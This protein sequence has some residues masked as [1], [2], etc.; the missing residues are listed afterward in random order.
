M[1]KYKNL[2]LTGAIVLSLVTSSVGQIVG[3]NSTE[4]TNLVY[5]NEG[6]CLERISNALRGI[7]QHPPA[8][9]KLTDK[10]AYDVS[11]INSYGS[12]YADALR[13]GSIYSK[14]AWIAFLFIQIFCEDIDKKLS[15]FKYEH[16]VFT[17]GYMVGALQEFK[18]NY[19]NIL[20]KWDCS[21]VDLI[22]EAKQA[23]IDKT[24]NG[25]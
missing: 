25:Q 22:E 10:P 3:S 11:T 12:P 15:N 23:I 7:I 24:L 4:Y 9:T 17:S 16:A 1:N 18:E 13:Y 21:M 5:S 2:V 19:S 14:S 6:V 20:Q 8:I